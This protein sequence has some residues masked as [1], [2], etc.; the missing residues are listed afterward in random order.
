[1]Y[2]LQYLVELFQHAKRQ[3]ELDIPSQ[4]KHH[5][6]VAEYTLKLIR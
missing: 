4:K 2:S 5:L 3:A 1:M 6:A